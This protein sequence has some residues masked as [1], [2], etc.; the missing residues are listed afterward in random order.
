G[1]PRGKLPNRA[2]AIKAKVIQNFAVFQLLSP[3]SDTSMLFESVKSRDAV[4]AIRHEV[5]RADKRRGIRD[6]GP[7]VRR[8]QAVL[9]GEGPIPRKTGTRPDDLC[10]LARAVDLQSRQ[11]RCKDQ[12]CGIDHCGVRREDIQ[13]CAR[14]S[15]VTEDLIRG[16]A[17][18][19]E[20]AVRSERQP[21]GAVQPAAAGSDEEIEK[22]P[23]VSI[24]SNHG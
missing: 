1:F 24:E 23:A 13:E 10:L 7:C 4:A 14:M 3:L 2:D 22:S 9:F 18:H 11:R 21:T 6:L 12:V 15:V 20:V 8:L 17:A 16:A 5:I 19:I